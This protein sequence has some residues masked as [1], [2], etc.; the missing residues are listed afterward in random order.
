MPLGIVVC[1]IAL[2][3]CYFH[4]EWFHYHVTGMYANLGHPHAQ[5]LM[6]DKLL[7]GKG[8]EMDEVSY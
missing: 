2:Y 4:F 5:H 1:L 6:G 3:L 7:F 8:V